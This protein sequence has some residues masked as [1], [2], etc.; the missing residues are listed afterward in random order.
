MMKTITL[1]LLTGLALAG[2]SQA[3]MPS[4]QNAMV[5]Q[6]IA[7]HQQWIM[8]RNQAI[9]QTGMAQDAQMQYDPA[10]PEQVKPKKH[11]IRHWFKRHFGRQQGLQASS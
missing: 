11:R 1:P 8:Q 4:N 3:G 2:Y 5:Y 10:H 6:H 9:R 7:Q